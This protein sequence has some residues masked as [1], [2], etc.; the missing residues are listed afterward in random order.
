MRDAS[1]EGCVEAA[2]TLRGLAHT[3][4]ITAFNQA[5]FSGRLLQSFNQARFSGTL[6]RCLPP[7]HPNTPHLL[8]FQEAHMSVLVTLS[9]LESLAGHCAAPHFVQPAGK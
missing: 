6:L 9:L 4:P 3:H 5:R 1:G 2:R 8:P 7:G